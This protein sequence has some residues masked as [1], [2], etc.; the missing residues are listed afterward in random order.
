MK[1]K[2][3]IYRWLKVIIIV[4]CLIGIALFYLQDKLVFRPKPLPAGSAYHF[5]QPFTEANIELDS[6]TKFNIV[7]FT[8]ADS[9]K[10]GVVLY[11]HGNRENINHYAPYAPNF[12]RNHYEVW[13]PDYPGFGKSTGTFSEQVLDDEALQVY[14]LAR[15]KY[16][17]GQIIIYG[18]S[19]GT[20]IAAELAS[21]RDCKKLIL[22][23]PYYSLTSLVRLL[24]W[25]YPVDMLLHYK[26]P[27]HNYL[28]KVTAPISIFHGTS[29]GV[30][31]Y[32]NA[33]RLKKVLKPSDEFIT[34][35]GGSHND[36][37]SFPLVQ[38]KIDSILAN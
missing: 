35:E 30:I 11:F 28:T 1:N 22:E 31:P 16:R 10:K 21:V 8:V 14:K 25:M 18:K 23:T 34:I 26:I 19:L 6:D 29:D 5:T 20:G 32:F 9:L 15:T 3:K 17:P 2:K 37:Y 13:M 12:T 36:L 27:T 7:Q 24:C 33:S 38:K 4:Y